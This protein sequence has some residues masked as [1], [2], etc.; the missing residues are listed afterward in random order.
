[1][2]MIEEMSVRFGIGFL[3]E[4]YADPTAPMDTRHRRGRSRDGPKALP[5]TQLEKPAKELGQRVEGTK[6]G[7]VASAARFARACGLKAIAAGGALSDYPGR[8][9]GGEQRVNRG[10][11]SPETTRKAGRRRRTPLARLEA[12]LGFEPS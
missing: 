6:K 8:G 3:A 4:M 9:K 11:K 7:V 1:M 12:R 5:T 2:I 10:W